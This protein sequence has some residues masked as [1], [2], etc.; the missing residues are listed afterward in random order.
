MHSANELVTSDRDA[1]QSP[2]T[3]IQVTLT[4]LAGA[5]VYGLFFN[6]GVWLSVIAYSI[7]PAER[8][9]H[10][11]V[12]YRDFLFNYTPGILWLNALLMKFFGVGLMPVHI[13]LLL[14][15][16]LTLVTLSFL[17]GKLIRGWLSL[18]PVALTLSWLGHRYIFNV[19]PT[20]YSM[21]FVLLGLV[22]MLKY[23]EAGSKRW[24]F[25]CGL[26]IGAVFVFKYN[27]GLALLGLGSGAL[28]LREWIK[29]NSNDSP[30]RAVSMPVRRLMIMLTGFGVIAAAMLVHL[31][32]KGALIPMIAHFLHHAA[33][34]SEERAVGLPS[35]RLALPCLVASAV[36]VGAAIVL[37]RKAPALAGV[38]VIAV[39][40]LGATIILIPGRGLLFKDSASAAVAYLPPALFSV[41][42]IWLIWSAKSSFRSRE[43]LKEWWSR[44][45]SLIVVLVF[46]LGAYSEVYPRADYYHLVRVLPPVFLLGAMTAHRIASEFASRLGAAS[47][48]TQA[49]WLC[50]AA[51]L[52]VLAAVGIDATWRPQFEGGFNL[53]DRTPI[54]VDRAEG[55]R[56]NPRDAEMIEEMTR[57]I[58]SNS[59]EGDS[60]FSFARRGGGFYFLANRKNPTKLLWWDSVGIGD[61]DR[62][63]PP[64]MMAEGRLKL[65]LIPD[66]L[67]EQGVFRRILDADYH[68]IGRIA[69]IEVYSR[70]D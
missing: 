67:S 43:L 53:I 69:G 2:T 61:E 18:A 49:A 28:L 1:K 32:S 64:R 34:Y 25:L 39:V 33:D 50:S 20:Q 6:R 29:S 41:I 13:G 22:F 59:A 35:I 68:S 70:N 8:V 42:A 4:I 46:A 56:T 66:N 30:A 12:P 44:N 16:V 54:A 14:F 24:L 17:S 47:R 26:A 11:E 21:L 7:A 5:A 58:T 3:L 52:I 23:E 36:A 40:A 10:G 60:M 63:E 9:L 45:G 38:F 55:V 48:S 57:L 19:H 15:K 51:P 65:V 62:G 31:A 27:V 37:A